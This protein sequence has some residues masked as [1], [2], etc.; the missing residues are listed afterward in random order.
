MKMKNKFVLL[1]A[2]ILTATFT[3]KAQET[4]TVFKG[5]SLKGNLKSLG[6]YV[7]P[8]IQY[9]GLAGG[10]APTV[11]FSGML[12]ANKKW[13]IGAGMYSTFT[14]YMPKQLSSTKALSFDAQYGGLKFE[15]TPKPDAVVHVSFPLMIGAGM[16]SIDSVN[17]SKTFFQAN[18]MD[19]E[20]HGM[21]SRGDGGHNEEMF[22]IVQPGINLETNLFK[23]GKVFIG[24]NYRLALDK[25]DALTAATSMYPQTT[26][27]QLS[28]FTINAGVKLGIFDYKLGG[29]KKKHEKK[30]KEA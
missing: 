23:Y 24:A 21:E 17:E 1:L 25:K 29:R 27:K 5:S 18:K 11:G 12:Q 26:A 14:D 16:A 28:G 2:V 15:Y 6:I 30:E 3:L 20:N 8:E 22:F 19:D 13:G 7:V 4:E 10:F 9:T